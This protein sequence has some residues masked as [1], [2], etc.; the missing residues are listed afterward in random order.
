MKHTII[1]TADI[2]VQV[3]EKNLRSSYEKCLSS[4]V[5]K[6]EKTNADIYVI[7][8][9]LFEYDQS[10]DAEK[11]V[12]YE[13]L[14]TV[15][16]MQSIK[17]VVIMCGNHDLEKERKR[18]DTLRNENSINTF[19]N[20]IKALDKKYSSKLTYLKYSEPVQSI[21]CDKLMW[22]PWSLEDGMYDYRVARTFMNEVDALKAS[23]KWDSIDP[24]FYM[25]A[26]TVY[27]MVK[28]YVEA[29]EEGEA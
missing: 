11:S 19:Y 4:I 17:E 23:M 28:P 21:A 10:N 2:Q 14:S 7:V 27:M 25:N 6:L 16:S 15:L 22:L 26:D 3:R 24:N 18:I 9:D 12:L 13:H 8:G 1:H 20:L 29:M 5:D